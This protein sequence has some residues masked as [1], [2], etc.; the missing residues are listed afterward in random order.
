L[1]IHRKLRSAPKTAKKSH[2]RTT[3]R[4]Q[5]DITVSIH[6]LKYNYWGPMRPIPCLV[7]PAI[8]STENWCANTVKPAS[9]GR[10]T[11]KTAELEWLEVAVSFKGKSLVKKNSVKTLLLSTKTFTLTTKIALDD[12]AVHCYSGLSRLCI[13]RRQDYERCVVA[14]Q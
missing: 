9:I 5:E 14:S 13:E 11:L 2:R 6:L 7:G 1:L 3:R 8:S 10:L 12:T 4:S